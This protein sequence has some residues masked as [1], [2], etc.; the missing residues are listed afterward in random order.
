MHLPEAVGA[1]PREMRIAQQQAAAVGG[2][3]AA[4][5]PG[6]GRDRP[7]LRAEVRR[8]QSHLRHLVGGCLRGRRPRTKDRVGEQAHAELDGGD[9]A[10]AP[11]LGQRHRLDPGLAGAGCGQLAGVVREV[12]V[13]AGHVAACHGIGFGARLCRRARHGL[14]V[15][16]GLDE[17]VDLIV[18]EGAQAELADGLGAEVLGPLGARGHQGLGG[19]AHVVLRVRVGNAVCQ[20]L[21]VGGDDVRNAVGRAADLHEARGRCGCRTRRSA[22]GGRAR[23][24]TRQRY[25]QQCPQRHAAQLLLIHLVSCVFDRL[26]AAQG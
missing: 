21:R 8:R 24:H 11:V 20:R 10:A 6:V 2:A 18:G 5:G 23:H 9:L 19:L 25:G 16:E 22:R 7:L 26:K 15:D 14:V 13:V 1:L 12:A 17:Q 3:V 4:E